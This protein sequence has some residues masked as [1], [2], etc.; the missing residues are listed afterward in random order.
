MIMNISYSP[1]SGPA[2]L[3]FDARRIDVI[4]DGGGMGW[5]DGEERVST[6][7]RLREICEKSV[8][9][10]LGYEILVP[11]TPAFCQP[12]WVAPPHADPTAG[13]RMYGDVIKWVVSNR[14]SPEKLTIRR[15]LKRAITHP[16]YFLD[17]IG[18]KDIDERFIGS[19]AIYRGADAWERAPPSGTPAMKGIIIIEQWKRFEN[20]V[21]LLNRILGHL[22]RGELIDE[23]EVGGWLMAISTDSPMIVAISYMILKDVLM[24]PGAARVGENTRMTL[25]S[26]VIAALP[27][28][29]AEFEPKVVV[30]ATRDR[31]SHVIATYPLPERIPH[32]T[33]ARELNERLKQFPWANVEWRD[34]ID[35]VH[36]DS[37]F[38]DHINDPQMPE[39]LVF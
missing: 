13:D 37:L 30:P 2:L 32:R 24:R 14:L 20:W 16:F 39:V 7:D 26:Y 4:M 12:S 5:V 17:A 28:K 27:E 6:Q 31:M 8:I 23:S 15:F 10:A 29:A 3:L 36:L 33:V 9:F 18:K 21:V 34:P 25:N 19:L 38:Q 11:D 22:T 35:E 1:C